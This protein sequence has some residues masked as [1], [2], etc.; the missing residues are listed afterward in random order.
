MDAAD[1]SYSA[2]AEVLRSRRTVRAFEADEVPI[3]TLTDLLDVAR[4]APS[5]FNTQPWRV[6]VLL[7][8]SKRDLSA[9]LMRAHQTATGSAHQAIPHAAP[10]EVR[11][12]RS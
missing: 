2:V 9:A 1:A 8:D 3:E 12:R 4:H 10:Q 5:V 11:A 6:H 7:G